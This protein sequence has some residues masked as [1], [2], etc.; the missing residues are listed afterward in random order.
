VIELFDHWFPA[1]MSRMSD[2][3]QFLRQGLETRGVPELFLERL[4]L[5]VDEVVS[6]AI[7]HGLEYR[8]SAEPIR[9]CV[10]RS[11]DG[12]HLTVEDMDVPADLVR[13]LARE[14]DARND[15]SAPAAPLERGRGMF[16]ITTF[17]EELSVTA[18]EGG[19]MRVSGRLQGS[20]Y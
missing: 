10:A 9:V 18:A 11:R 17:L 13:A 15:S 3:R 8:A 7:E 12:L 4:L 6:N 20:L 16:L 1:D 2:I 19:G 5:V 14:F